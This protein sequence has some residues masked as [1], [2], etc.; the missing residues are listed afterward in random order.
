VREVENVLNRAHLM[1]DGDCIT[2]ADIPP[3]ITRA[4]PALQPV[5][6]PVNPQSAVGDA[7]AATEGILREQLRR[8]EMRA[9][10]QAIAAAGGDRRVA[11]GRLGIGLSSLYRKLEEFSSTAGPDAAASGMAAK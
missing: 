4:T 9:I 5:T 11:A 8:F 1:A 2:L 7:E 3:Q 6:P 10:S